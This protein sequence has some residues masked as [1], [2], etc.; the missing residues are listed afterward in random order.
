MDEVCLNS[1]PVFNED[2][3]FDVEEE[4]AL[5]TTHSDEIGETQFKREPPRPT[6]GLEFESFDEAY[7]FYNC[8][9]K[10]QGFGIRVSNSWFRSKRKE[11]YRAKLS[12]SSAGFKKKSEA[13]HPRPETRTGCPAMLVIR[14]VDS[15]RWRIVEVE[16][17]HNHPV[18]PEIK[19]FYKSHK[20]MILAGKK[21]QE[22][23]RVTEVY[24]IKLYRNAAVDGQSNGFSNS[25]E[26]DSQHPVDHSKHLELTE[27]DAH[28]VY[29]YFCRMKLT[30]PN[31]FY[32]MDLDDEGHLR[33][34]FWADPRSRDAYRYFCDTI[35]IDTTSLANK[36]EL[37]LVSFVGV[38]HHGQSV[39]LGCGFIGQETVEH[40]VWIFRSWLTCMHGHPPQ[41]IIT[42]QCKQLQAAVSE[43][44][45]GA[46]HCFC[47]WYIIQRVPEKLGGLQ[48]Y[49]AIKKRLHKAVYES[50]KIA[51]FETSWYEMIKCHGLGDN[52]WLQMLYEDRQ[53]WVPVYLK[54]ISF[55]GMIPIKE[56]ETLNAF[57]DRYVHKHTSFKEFVDKYDLAL[58]RKHLKEAMADLESKTTT[59]ELKTRCNFELQL[60]KIYTKEIFKRFQS[61]VEGMYSCFNTRQVNANGQIITYIV[62]ERVEA[63]GSEKE[64]KYFEVLYE[65]SQVDIRCIC[66][67]FNFK[68]YLCRHALNVLNYNGVE[69][70][71]ARYI[72]P[73]WSKDF[74]RKFP[75]DH[76]L[77]NADVNSPMY[78]YNTLYNYA[79]QVVVEGAQFEEHYKL[80]LQQVQ[81]LLKKFS[82]LEDDSVKL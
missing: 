62:K 75:L 53:M 13:N 46:R 45:P 24:T 44:F 23:A 19:R 73:R 28:A 22:P 38:N 17:Q 12:C 58:Q 25:D 72:L 77:H 40:F 5:V 65:T 36:F 6:I 56:N 11:R 69:E 67:L 71:P 27:G 15:Q 3:E 32:L 18:S 8:Y 26:R 4:G 10:E 57:F 59:L 14:L 81:E 55:A 2:D 51:E 16:L 29:N 20:K 43:V 63:V 50:L 31:F 34:V 74:K 78:W 66:S 42:D 39:L 64:V 7:D 49:E 79:I 47:L 33:N 61:E 80:A 82:L 1:E 30:N 41:V 68:G 76:A 9:A 37:P 60:S 52:K 54:D 48:G 70:I 21:A 35:A